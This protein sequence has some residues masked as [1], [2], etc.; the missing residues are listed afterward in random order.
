MLIENYELEV[1]TPPCDPGAERYA[2]KAHLTADISEIL[3]Y[4]NATLCSAVSSR[5]LTPWLGKKAGI[6][7]LFTLMKLPPPTWRMVTVQKRNSKGCLTF[8]TAPGSIAPRLRPT[9]PPASIR[10]R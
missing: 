1:F 5:K 3:P 10:H 4:L 7:L 2:A 8:S 9:T 6:I